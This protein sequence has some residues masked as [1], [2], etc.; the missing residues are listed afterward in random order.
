MNLKAVNMYRDLTDLYEEYVINLQ[1]SLEHR[2]Y[3]LNSDRCYW[4][5]VQDKLSSI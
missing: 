1:D 3:M 2:A 4:E 5:W